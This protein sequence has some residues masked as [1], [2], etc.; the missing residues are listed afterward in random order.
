MLTLTFY[1]KIQFGFLEF[2]LQEF[3]ELIV[4]FVANVNKYIEY[5]NI[6]FLKKRPRSFFVL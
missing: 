5:M 1:V 3:L 6:D 4:D 2:I